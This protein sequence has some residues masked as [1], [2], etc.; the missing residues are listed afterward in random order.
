MQ[1]LCLGGAGRICREAALDLVQFSSFDRITIADFDEQAGRDVAEWLGDPRVDFVS[2]D[3]NDEAAAVE[4]MSPYDIVMDGT[5]ISLNDVST[6]CIANAGCHG[7]NLNG[8]GEEYKYDETFRRHGTVHVPGFG[9]TPGTT[10]MMAVHAAEQLETVETI[11]VS[12]GAFRPIAFSRSI[13]ETTTYE[14]DP[15]LPGRMVYEDGEF[16]QVPPFARPREIP[17]PEPYGTHTQYIIPHSETITLAQY[18]EG[19][20]VRLIEVRGTW[21][22]ANMQLIRALN[23]LGDPAEPARQPRRPRR[24]RARCDRRV[25]DQ[26]R[27][28]Y[29]DR[30]LRLR[31]A[32]R[33]HRHEGWSS[34]HAHADPH[35]SAV[36]W[37]GARLGRAA[38]LH[39]ERRHS[40]GDRR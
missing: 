20:G 30:T 24:R 27:G 34:R 2:I 9:M 19:R 6:R 7:I 1:V 28:G 21:P 10:N 25:P 23:D 13:A 31:A 35:P 38:V 11:R 37:I 12:H 16:K 36:R 26:L 5:T 17:L 14:Y 4:V 40:D 22:P 3:I 32:R 8:F 15:D 39:A 18:L 29:D 33:G